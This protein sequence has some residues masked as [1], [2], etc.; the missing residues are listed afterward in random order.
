MITGNMQT[1]AQGG[2]PGIFCWPV[3]CGSYCCFCMPWSQVM[4]I[5]LLLQARASCSFPGQLSL[6]WCLC[7]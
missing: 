2:L 1:Q 3:G 4:L 7:P 5:P 6:S